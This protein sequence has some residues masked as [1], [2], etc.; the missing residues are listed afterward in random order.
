[1][2]NNDKEKWIDE[3]MESMKGSQ[4]AKPDSKLFSKIQSQLH[5]HNAN[6]VSMRQWSYA[7]AAAIILLVLN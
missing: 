1:M 7:A 6:V 2:E 5:V 3:V 4:R